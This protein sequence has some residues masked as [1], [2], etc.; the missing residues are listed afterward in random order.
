[1][2][3]TP[4]GEHDRA[5]TRGKLVFTDSEDVFSLDHVE[6]LVLVGVYVEGSVERIYLFDDRERASGGLGARFDQDDR[7]RERQALSSR[8][9]EVVGM[10]APIFDGANLARGD[11][12]RPPGSMSRMRGDR[13]AR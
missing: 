11:Q 6:E 10:S 8:C 9:V 7:A 4:R 13:G 12:T 2:R 3:H 1:V 5:G